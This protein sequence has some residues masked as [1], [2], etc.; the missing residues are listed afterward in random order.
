MAGSCDFCIRI[1]KCIP[2]L[3]VLSVVAWSYFAYVVQLCFNTVQSNVERVFDLMVYHILLFF[4]LWAYWQTVC[5]PVFTVPRKFV[6]SAEDQDRFNR[7]ENEGAQKQ[8]IEEVTQSLPLATRTASGGFRYCHICSHIKPDRSHHCSVCGTCV[9]KMDHHCPWVNNCVSFSNYKYF[10]LFLGYALLYCLFIVMSTLQYFIEFWEGNPDRVQRFNVLFLF[11]VAA[12]FLFSLVSLFVYHLYLVSH[13]RTTLEA[14]RAPV[15]IRG[16]DKNGFNLG[17][18][19]NFTEV[20]GDDVLLW[21]V[22]VFTSMGDGVEFPVRYGYSSSS[23][24]Y[25]SMGRT[26]N[27]IGDGVEYPQRT[28]D[29]A[30]DHLLG[31]DNWTDDNDD[32]RFAP[33]VPPLSPRTAKR[34]LAPTNLDNS[35]SYDSTRSSDQCEEN[36]LNTGS[37]LD[38]QQTFVV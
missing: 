2:V 28:L 33:Y 31:S 20:F 22:P 36:G 18:G 8:I 9:L 23:N 7:A 10:I 29:P 3:F 1:F 6:L 14:F 24:R 12:M 32:F 30:S 27:S 34:A 17:C 15:F 25:H 35:S 13:N 16:P 21:F 11:F 38:R 26:I 19:P 37:N 4:F 5:T